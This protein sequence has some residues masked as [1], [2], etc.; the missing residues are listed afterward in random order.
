M[1]ALLIQTP[2]S[3]LER[4]DDHAAP[5]HHRQ[6]D[7]SREEERAAA[8]RP[9]DRAA[10]GHP[11]H[12]GREHR[13]AEPRERPRADRI[14]HQLDDH[15]LL[16]DL[17]Q[18]PPLRR[19]RRRPARATPDVSDRSRHLHR[20]LVRLRAGRHGRRPLRRPG[21]PGTRSSDALPGSTRDHHVRLPRQPAR[22]SSRSLGR[23]RRRRRCDRRPRR[24]P[25]DR[26]HRL[27]DDLLRQP[28]RRRNPRDRRTED[29]PGR[30]PQAA[31]AGSR[32]PRRRARNDESRRDRLRDHPGR[33]CG[34]DFGSDSPVRPR[35]P[36]R[37]RRLRGSR[38]PHRHP[39]LRIERLADRAVGGGSS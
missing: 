2:L 37:P 16:A 32:P 23:G 18:P 20:V 35:R 30:H 26:V 9:A 8:V 27:A 17:R 19:P 7:T 14:E 34:L 22:E 3:D 6:P 33:G 4:N 12:H 11:R 31:L 29:R 38:A 28:P 13:A 15:E 1:S 24:R 10:D 25:P 39:L 36:R 21:R 5:T